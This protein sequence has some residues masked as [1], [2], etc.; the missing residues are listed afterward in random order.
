MEAGERA[1]LASEVAQCSVTARVLFA[2]LARRVYSF[3]A[4]F[5]V[6]GV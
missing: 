4:N 6:N 3:M 2:S 5:L 1:R